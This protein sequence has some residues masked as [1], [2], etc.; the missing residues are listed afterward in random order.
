LAQGARQM[1]RIIRNRV[2][3]RAQPRSTRSQGFTLLEIVIII[4]ITGILFAIAAAGWGAFLNVH[5]LNTAQ[6][7]VFLAMRTAQTSARHHHVSWQTD[8]RQTNQSLQ[9]A[10]HPDGVTPTESHWNSLN[11]HIQLDPETTLRRIGSLWRVE[12]N[13]QG[14]VNGSLGRITLSGKRGGKAKRCVI[15]STLLGNLRK[16]SDQS[17]PQNGRFCY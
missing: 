17:K 2:G 6:E 12:F 13:H 8:F 11:P 10:I 3:R 7:Q 9:W 14:R 16:S 15:V 5:R 1:E 4:A